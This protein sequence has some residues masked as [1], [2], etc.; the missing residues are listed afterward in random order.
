[1]AR[2]RFLAA[3]AA[4]PGG[5]IV[6]YALFMLAVLAA[7][8]AFWRGRQLALPLFFAT[9]VALVLFMASDMTSPLGLSF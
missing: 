3:V 5:A 4:N 8:Y 9:L 1:L 6:V 7:L 2:C